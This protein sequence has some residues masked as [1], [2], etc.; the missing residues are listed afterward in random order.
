[1]PF[2]WG[3]DHNF[4]YFIPNELAKSKYQ[5]LIDAAILPEWDE[6]ECMEDIEEHG[7][8]P[9]E[10]ECQLEHVVPES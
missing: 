10:Y 2:Q 4:T 6:Q 5:Y 1:M 8:D 9:K 3:E 7:D